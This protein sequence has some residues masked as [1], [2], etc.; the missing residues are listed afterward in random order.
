[1]EGFGSGAGENLA[2]RT[3]GPWVDEFNA[4]AL[5][6]PSPNKPGAQELA[7]MDRMFPG[8]NPWERLGGGGG[9]QAAAATAHN[10]QRRA[11]DTAAGATNRQTS[12]G[13]QNVRDQIKL[14]RETNETKERIAEI[15]A[16]AAKDTARINQGADPSTGGP[17][18][19][20]QRDQDLRSLQVDYDRIRTDNDARRTIALVNK[21]G[22]EAKNQ[23]AQALLAGDQAAVQRVLER[24]HTAA[25]G[26]EEYRLSRKEELVDADISRSLTNLVTSSSEFTSEILNWLGVLGLGWLAKDYLQKRT[27]KESI[28]QYGKKVNR[29]HDAGLRTRADAHRQRF[30]TRWWRAGGLRMRGR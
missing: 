23:L 1:M 15:T 9:G 13:R 12:V 8:T 24:L 26:M 2:S 20:Q 19:Y 30:W 7:A 6:I 18:A 28:R 22:A 29:A 14:G 21:A 5:G 10:A 25:A 3:F 17:T 27:G 16:A 4:K 11:A